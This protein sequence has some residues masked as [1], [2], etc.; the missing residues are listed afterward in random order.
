M[1]QAFQEKYDQIAGGAPSGV[2][3]PGNLKFVEK[4]NLKFPGF[5]TLGGAPLVARSYFF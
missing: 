2:K 1:S 5:L 3:N 4:S